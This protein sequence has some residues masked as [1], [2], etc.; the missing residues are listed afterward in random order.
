MHIHVFIWKHDL[1]DTTTK[2]IM[3]AASGL[4]RTLAKPSNVCL[5]SLPGEDDWMLG[6][7]TFT[8]LVPGPALTEIDCA[9]ASDHYHTSWCSQYVYKRI[10]FIKHILPYHLRL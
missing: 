2:E 7:T 3:A 6:T 1:I 9:S 8:S 5:L 4:Q 10:S